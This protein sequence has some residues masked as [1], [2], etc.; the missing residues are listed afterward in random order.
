MKLILQEDKCSLLLSNPINTATQLKVETL[1]NRTLQQDKIKL[2]P[3]N[4][5]A[6]VNNGSFDVGKM[7]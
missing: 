2:E 6:L 1:N 3:V 4:Q 7:W 5:S